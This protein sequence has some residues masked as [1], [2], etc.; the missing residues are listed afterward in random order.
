MKPTLHAIVKVELQNL[1]NVISIYPISDSQWVALL[2]VV[3]NKYGKWRIFIDYREL[4]KV[5][6]KDHFPLPFID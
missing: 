6:S 1:L 4:N 3:P 5:T 2:V